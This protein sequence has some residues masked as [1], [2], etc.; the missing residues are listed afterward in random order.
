MCIGCETVA[1][2]VN[3]QAPDSSETAFPMIKAEFLVDRLGEKME[4]FLGPG[5]VKDLS[6]K[7]DCSLPAFQATL[8]Y[9]PRRHNKRVPRKGWEVDFRNLLLEETR[10]LSDALAIKLFGG[11]I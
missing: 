8:H 5:M 4:R 7:S 10:K 6:Q 9:Y 3:F 2:G 11:C 1:L